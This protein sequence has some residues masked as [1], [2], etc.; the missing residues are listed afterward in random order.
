MNSLPIRETNNAP[1]GEAPGTAN[2]TRMT[3]REA[4]KVIGVAPVLAALGL[5]ACDMEKAADRVAALGQGPY[6]PEF[7]TDPEWDTI[8]VLVDYIIP[9]DDRSGSATDARVPEFMDFMLADEVTSN[10]AREAMRSGLAWLDEEST[11]R[12]AA[13][14]VEATDEQRRDLLD[15]ISWPD[16][17]AP[18]MAD[19]VAFFN[20]LRDM[21]ASGFFSSEMG[22]QDVQYIG[23]T[24]VPE[25]TGCPQPALDKLGVSNDLMNH[26]VQPYD[27]V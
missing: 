20:R 17:A 6:E 5:A 13:A 3:R 9:R 19:G 1:D 21:T 26:R 11:G 12:F 10:T 16:R 4:V 8:Q 23:H 24:F 2:R 14:F 22:W 7:F 25:W 15:D 18:E 27:R